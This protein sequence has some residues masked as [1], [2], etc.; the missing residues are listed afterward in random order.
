MA[1][2]QTKVL[3]SD[4]G[5]LNENLVASIYPID[6]KGNKTEDTVV[7]CVFTDSNLELSTTW[8]SPFENAGTQNVSPTLQQLV[9][10]GSL[11]GLLS[12]VD[13]VFGSDLQRLAHGLEGRT[14]VTKLNST[15]VYVGNQP[16]KFNVTA[17][18]RAWADPVKEVHQPFNQLMEWALPV[19]LSEEGS[20][21][22]RLLDQ[23]LSYQS[24]FPSAAPVML[25]VNYKGATYWP[26]VIENITKDTNAPI[27]R[28]G[29]FTELKVPMLLTTLTAIDRRD[30]KKFVS[31]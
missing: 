15:Q 12:K 18:F 10:S 23:G 25:A 2:Q 5:G 31:Q 1:E 21:A 16:A 20:L 9:Q 22:A 17:L 11:S 8:A 26:M 13:G 19:E 6:R 4:W 3:T 7:K 14:S 27:D 30:Y 28:N 24:T 29:N